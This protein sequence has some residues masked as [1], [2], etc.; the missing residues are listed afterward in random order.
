MEGRDEAL[1]RRVEERERK[2][3]EREADRIRTR[4]GGQAKN[5]PL[6]LIHAALNHI[7]MWEVKNERVGKC[8]TY[9]SQ[10][11]AASSEEE[12]GE[13]EAKTGGGNH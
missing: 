11:G 7:V 4:F 3:K 10:R 9:A 1:T 2:R 5:L 13:K 12:G 8:Y 6:Q